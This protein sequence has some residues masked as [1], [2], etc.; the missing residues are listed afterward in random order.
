MI[1]VELLQ[2]SAN[3]VVL[4][5]SSMV[6]RRACCAADVMLLLVRGYVSGYVAVVQCNRA[7]ACSSSTYL[8][9]SSRMMTL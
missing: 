3:R 2:A 7:V 8:S 6:R 1:L 9:A 5:Y 4:E